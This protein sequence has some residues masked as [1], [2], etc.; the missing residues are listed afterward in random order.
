MVSN[1]DTCEEDEDVAPATDVFAD[2]SPVSHAPSSTRRRKT[3]L[4]DEALSRV[5]ATR[6][7]FSQ[8][9]EAPSAAEPAPRGL[10]SRRLSGLDDKDQEAIRIRIRTMSIEQE[11]KEESTPASALGR[12]SIPAEERSSPSPAR[13]AIPEGSVK[14]VGNFWENVAERQ[15]P[16]DPPE[17]LNARRTS[18]Q[19]AAIVVQEAKLASE[20]AM[21]R[22]SMSRRRRKSTSQ[23]SST[24]AAPADDTATKVGELEGLGDGAGAAVGYFDALVLER[25]VVLEEQAQQ[26]D[27]SVS[28]HVQMFRQAVILQR[29]FLRLVCQVDQEHD[30]TTRVVEESE[31]NIESAQA[32]VAGLPGSLASLPLCRVVCD[33]AEAL[34][35]I[36]VECDNTAAYVEERVE[37]VRSAATDVRAACGPAGEQWY[38]Q[39][40]LLLEGLHRIVAKFH[41]PTIRWRKDPPPCD[42]YLRQYGSMPKA[43]SE[44]ERHA[45]ELQRCAFDARM[46]KLSDQTAV[47]SPREHLGYSPIKKLG[48]GAFGQVVLVTGDSETLF[49]CK[50]MAKIG[51]IDS[52]QAEHALNERNILF[53]SECP[54][55]VKL[56]DHC[57][58]SASLYMVRFQN[59]RAICT[60]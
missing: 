37:R 13:L 25:F 43:A 32:Y 60:P 1:L 27:K 29:D 31:E 38:R 12:L 10:A 30:E 15:G 50:A 49:A 54:H 42:W 16:M 33:A 23:R 35:W 17:R 2:E 5:R 21:R 9:D 44:A 3:G 55:I 36:C 11:K 7:A 47:L 8:S 19:L 46:K 48:A 28:E 59:S 58:D 52:L 24:S 34:A 22:L 39:L 41:A 4:D 40:L 20:Q 45:Y 18:R 53:G 6:A 57:Q 14:S 56:H 26:I 51:V